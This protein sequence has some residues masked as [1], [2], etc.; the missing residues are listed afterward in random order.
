MASTPPPPSPSAIRVPRAP[1]HGAKY[2]DW[3]PYPT[4]YSTRLASQRAA[5]EAQSAPPLSHS[6]SSAQSGRPKRTLSPSSPG[7]VKP[8]SKKAAHNH[9]SSSRISPFD[10]APSHPRTSAAPSSR[11]SAE[12]ALPTPVKTPSKKQAIISSSGSATPR[13]LFPQHLHPSAEKWITRAPLRFSLTTLRRKGLARKQGPLAPAPSISI[14][15]DSRDRIPV[16]AGPKNNPFY[17]PPVDIDTQSAPSGIPIHTDSR[18]RIPANAGPKGG[19]FRTAPG[20]LDGRPATRSTLVDEETPRGACSR[21]KSVYKSFDDMDESDDEDDLGLFANRPD[22]LAKNPNCLKGI[23][24]LKRSEIKP[25]VLFARPDGIRASS[26]PLDQSPSIIRGSNNPASL[27]HVEASANDDE[28]DVTDVED[29][30]AAD[31]ATHNPDSS[32][33][34]LGSVSSC[35]DIPSVSNPSLGVTPSPEGSFYEGSQEEN[36]FA[37][38]AQVADPGVSTGSLYEWLRSGKKANDREKETASDRMK[39]HRETRG[40]PYPRTR[41]A[42]LAEAAAGPDGSAHAPVRAPTRASLRASARAA[43]SPSTPGSL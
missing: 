21:G 43:A 32:P 41:M 13:T 14:H 15:T 18:D 17:T 23:K 5:K 2:D 12:R 8:S 28:E 31:E 35:G 34:E 3:E 19:L 30:E 9:A 38:V 16:N 24:P 33:L 4:R 39:R 7:T 42:K 25:K 37:E 26:P 22:L 1:R 10:S 6:T 27:T 11:S 20:I 29:N 40:S 36:P